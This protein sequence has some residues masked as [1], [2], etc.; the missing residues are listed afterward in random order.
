MK[1]NYFLCAAGLAALL[2]S[3]CAGQKAQMDFIGLDAA[4]R[5]ALEDASLSAADVEFTASDLASRSGVD[6]Y[7]VDFTNEGQT[8]K[9]DIDALTGSIID[10]STPDTSQGSTAA[11]SQN[12]DNNGAADGSQNAGKTGTASDSQNTD[13]NST[14]DD[15]QNTDK[16]GSASGPQNSSKNGTSASQQNAGKTGAAADSAASQKNGEAVITQEDAKAKALKH[17]GVSSRDAVFL[18]CELDYEH[19]RTV[20]EIEF[21]DNGGKEYD[22]EIDASDGS[23]I[24]YDYDTETAPSHSG[25]GEKKISEEKAKELALAQVPGAS[26]SDIF[27]FETDLDDG[28]MEYEGKIIYNG[29]EYE[30]EIDAYSGAIRSWE[31][32]PMD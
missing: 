32:E 12:T 17:A 22:Y 14:A 2:F 23:I 11:D 3:G 26:V 27:E 8:Y 1:A 6:Y 9:Y 4:K 21:Y 5:V 19:G 15:S 20:Y 31:A 10:S 24:K 28:I 25:T 18:K 29:M 7:Q 30:F 16:N 13:K